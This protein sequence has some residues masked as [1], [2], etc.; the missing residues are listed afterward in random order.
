MRQT[1]IID[2]FSSLD[3]TTY[4][5][6]IRVMSLA[7]EFEIAND[8]KDNKLS[9]AALIHDIGKVFVA[10]RILDK[11]EILSF[12]ER[13]LVD[14]HAYIGYRILKSFGVEEDVCRIVLYHHGLIPV[15]LSDMSYFN[16]GDVKNKALILRTIDA[17]EALTSDRPYHNA[18]PISRAINVLVQEKT[19]HPDVIAF[20]ES[21]VE[22]SDLYGAIDK[23][24]YARDMK[25]VCMILSMWTEQI[26][27]LSSNKLKE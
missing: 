7:R 26:T 22:K 14:L 23:R 18:L 11:V 5:H 8:F 3:S 19:H 20:L 13:E 4:N 24:Y 25:T 15:T 21:K 2:L 1:N 27:E 12:I 9:T 10:P 16:S 17:F 6:S